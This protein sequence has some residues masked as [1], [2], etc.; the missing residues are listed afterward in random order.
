MDAEPADDGTHDEVKT[1]VIRI[2]GNHEAAQ[3]TAANLEA[4]GIQCWVNSDDCGGMYPNLTAAS[5]VRLRVRTEDA[6]RAV[7]LLDAEPS[8]QELDQIE[9]EAAIPV[10]AEI[11]SK[12]K[13]AWGQITLG[14]LMGICLCLLYQWLNHFGTRTYYYNGHRQPEEARTYHDGRLVEYRRDRNH[15]GQWDQWSYYDGNGNRTRSEY[16][17]N[18]DGRPDAFYFYTND[19]L[20]SSERDTD[21]NGISDEFCT[22]KYDLL[23]QMEIRPNGSKFATTRV[24]YRNDVLSEVWRGGDSNGNFNEVVRFDPFFNPISTNNPARFRFPPP[25]NQ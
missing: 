3:L 25:I 10:P 17:D 21:F 7:A 23:Q 20:V 2:F 22:Y 1:L 5:G 6:E 18:F 8:P 24:V 14:I 12:L 9:K 19:E 11:N 15:D 13:L 16:D 4:H